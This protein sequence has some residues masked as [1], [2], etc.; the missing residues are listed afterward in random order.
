VKT[1]FH[2]FGHALN[3]V[4]CDNRLQH[5]FGARGALDLVELPSHILER[6]CEDP[7]VLGELMLCDDPN[8][9]PSE[10]RARV[11]SLLLRESFCKGLTSLESLALPFLDAALHQGKPVASTAQLQNL[12]HA[13]LCDVLILRPPP[14]TFPHMSLNHFVTYAGACHAYPFAD[15]IADRI[16]E[17]H[18]KGNLRE[19]GAGRDLA[20]KLYRPG[21]TVNALQVL[22]ELLPD[23][24]GLQSMLPQD[25]TS[26]MWAK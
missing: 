19:H 26:V 5:L 14:R 18:L 12:V 16:Y 23:W 13:T 8:M 9:G 21:G 7:I 6:V 25:E 10:L 2:E 22:Q 20:E 24:R 15:A 4:L 3:S 17:V 11:D 1:L